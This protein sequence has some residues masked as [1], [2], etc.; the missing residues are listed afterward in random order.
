MGAI[1]GWIRTHYS[2]F[3]VKVPIEWRRWRWFQPR[4]NFSK[5]LDQPFNHHTPYICRNRFSI[6]NTCELSHVLPFD[7]FVLSLRMTQKKFLKMAT[8]RNPLMLLHFD[9]LAF[10]LHCWQRWESS[11]KW[12]L[13][14]AIL[15]I[16]HSNKIFY[17]CWQKKRFWCISAYI[18]WT[19]GCPSVAIWNSVLSFLEFP[20]LSC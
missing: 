6:F 20:P 13:S 18:S 19:F 4:T 9:M 3:S 11:Y 1:W 5:M 17:P 12:Q 8:F 14:S 16:P 2:G 7:N 15:L 10:E